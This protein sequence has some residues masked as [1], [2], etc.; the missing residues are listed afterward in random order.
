MARM[1]LMKCYLMLQNVRVTAF[2]VSELL[3]KKAKIGKRV[4]VGRVGGG[5]GVELGFMKCCSSSNSFLIIPGICLGYGDLVTKF[6][7]R[8]GKRQ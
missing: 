8:I 5:G 3:R 4:R 1:F 6:G 7:H 2:T